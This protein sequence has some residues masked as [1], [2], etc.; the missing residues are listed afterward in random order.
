MRKLI[1]QYQ[2]QIEELKKE[3]EALRR[4][5]RKMRELALRF[6]DGMM[7]FEL[8][9]SGVRPLYISD[10]ICSF[11]GYSREEWLGLT[12]ESQ[13]IATFVS[14]S[15]IPLEVFLELLQQGEAEFDFI[16]VAEGRQKRVRAVCTEPGESDLHYV[17][18]YEIHRKEIA[19]EQPVVIRTFGYF[20]VFV[21]GKAVAFRNEKSKELLALLVDRRG[22]FVTSSEAIS[23]LWENEDVNQLTLARYRKVALRLK[24][25][26]EEYGIAHI[27]ETVDGKRRIV[28]QAVS[29]DLFDH[30]QGGQLF[31]GSYLTNYS[32]AEVTLSELGGIQE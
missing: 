20:D 27:V 21:E 26:L 14:R 29:C 12:K 2:K 15:G 1:E 31:K 25:L 6:T 4:M 19:V 7:A 32:W 30:L 3:N 22:G 5:N 10:N 16:D 9:Q 8:S 28:P 13:P 24:N 18:L 11:F 17:L 23:Y